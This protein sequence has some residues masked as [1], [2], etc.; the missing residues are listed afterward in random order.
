MIASSIFISSEPLVSTRVSL[1]W[2]PALP[3][4]LT[5]TLVLTGRTGFFLDLRVFT[6]GPRKGEIDWATAGRKSWL[7]DSREFQ[8]ASSDPDPDGMLTLARV[9]R[10]FSSAIHLHRRLSNYISVVSYIGGLR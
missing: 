9:T 8:C 10:Q 7:G 5:N 2:P 4:E 1:R 3:Q 6:H